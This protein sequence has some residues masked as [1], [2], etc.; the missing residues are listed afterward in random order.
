MARKALVRVEQKD[1]SPHASREERERAFKYML[2][3]FKRQV[4][5]SGIL[6]LYKEKQYYETPSQKKK[7]K[8]KEAEIE[9][10]K[11]KVREHFG[12]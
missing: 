8:R 7:R 6:S 4:N 11:E 9:S 12:K 10:R 2:T 5:E 3:I 1:I